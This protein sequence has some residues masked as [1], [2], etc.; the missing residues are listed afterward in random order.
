MKRDVERTENSCIADS[1]ARIRALLT[2]I[3]IGLA[4]NATVEER[5]SAVQRVLEL[6]HQ[7]MQAHHL[8]SLG[9]RTFDAIAKWTY[10]NPTYRRRNPL[11][12][13][14]L[15]LLDHRMRQIPHAQDARLGVLSGDREHLLTL[16]ASGPETYEGEPMILARV[17]RAVIR[18]DSN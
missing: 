13:A 4:P 14:Q 1:I 7:E 17:L 16:L 3:F 6:V 8:V 9:H 12:R 15:L 18:F 10:A 11:T 5:Q 2:R